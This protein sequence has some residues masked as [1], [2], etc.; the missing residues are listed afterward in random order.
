[1]SIKEQRK[2]F[3][4]NVKNVNIHGKYEQIICWKVMDVLNVGEH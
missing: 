3:Y 2:R 4:V 1:M